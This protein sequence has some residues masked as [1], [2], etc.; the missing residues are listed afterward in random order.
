MQFEANSFVVVCLFVWMLSVKDGFRGVS[1]VS[2]NHSGFVPWLRVR[3]KAS[4]G[5]HS[6]LNNCVTGFCSELKLRKS[7]DDHF[8]GRHKG[9]LETFA[10]FVLQ[11]HW[12]LCAKIPPYMHSKSPRQQNVWKLLSKISRTTP[13]CCAMIHL[14]DD[15]QSNNYS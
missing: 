7:S 12:K 9:K 6:V 10:K 3:Y 8:F 5:T 2:R 11:R 13:E 14:E 4:R 1:E 15:M